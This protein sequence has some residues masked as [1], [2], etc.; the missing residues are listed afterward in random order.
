MSQLS[1]IWSVSVDDVLFD[2]EEQCDRTNPR[3]AGCQSLKRLIYAL[4][5]YMKLNEQRGKNGIGAF[6]DFIKSKYRDYLN[7]IIHL[8]VHENDLEH[9]HHS[10]FTEYGMAQCDLKKC[11]F[12]DRR[13]R[14]IADGGHSENGVDSAF[15]TNCFDSVHHYLFHLFD[16]GLRTLR[17]DREFQ[18]RRNDVFEDEE[19]NVRYIDNAF[20]KRKHRMKSIRREYAD[21]FGRCSGDNNKFTI[22]GHAAISDSLE[23]DKTYFDRFIRAL[24]HSNTAAIRVTGYLLENAFDSDAVKQDIDRYPNLQNSNLCAFVDDD[25]AIDR[26]DLFV[27]KRRCMWL[28]SAVSLCFCTLKSSV[29]SVISAISRI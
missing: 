20:S 5:F 25:A 21:F 9:I 1:T 29:S 19:D 12:S 10:L 8:S 26:M 2:G 4:K 22:H 14:A 15:Y 11:T 7:D 18:Q 6:T 17:A 23:K 28:E 13:N 16:L 27:N 3:L 24:P